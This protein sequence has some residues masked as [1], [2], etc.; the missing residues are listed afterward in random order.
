MGNVDTVIFDIG[1]VLV[2]FCW[3]KAFDNMNLS[4]DIWDR[5]YKATV[6]NQMWNEFDRGILSEKEIVEGF[7]SNDPEIED[8]ILDFMNNHYKEIVEK[9]DYAND[10]IDEL[11]NHGYKVYFLSN[12]SKKGFAELSSEL[13]F[14]EKG[15]GA[16]ISYRVKQIKPDRDIYETLIDTYK[17]IPEK[18]VFIDDTLPNIE[19]AR[20][21]GFNAI[22]FK[23]RQ[24]VMGEL[25]ALGVS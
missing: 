11:K 10:W 17:I 16:V 21:L 23:N 3:R 13:D 6:G 25:D 1:N 19:T 2:D 8:V 9:F 22:Q 24:Q 20:S 4:Q 14:V 5:L 15:H 18:A 12:F 7:I